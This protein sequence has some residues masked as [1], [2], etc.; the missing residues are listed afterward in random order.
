[1]Q[2]GPIPLISRR[3]FATLS[4][5]A[6]IQ[7]DLP[8]ARKLQSASSVSPCAPTRKDGSVNLQCAPTREEISFSGG[9]FIEKSHRCRGDFFLE[10]LLHFRSI[11]LAG[12]RGL[13]NKANTNVFNGIDGRAQER[14]RQS[15]FKVS[16]G[17]CKEHD[18]VS[19]KVSFAFCKVYSFLRGG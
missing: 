9:D 3:L 16:F 6:D 2:F 14:R 17:F 12:R 10:R 1:M 7:D 19:F 13:E 18:Q 15:L 4:W 8:S 5:A 11:Y